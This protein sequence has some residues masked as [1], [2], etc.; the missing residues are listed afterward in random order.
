MNGYRIGLASAPCAEEFPRRAVP[1]RVLLRLIWG[2]AI[3]A[4]MVVGYKLLSL[5]SAPDDVL[6]APEP[7]CDLQQSR[8]TAAL[9]GGTAEL[10][11]LTRPIPLARPFQVVLDTRGVDA[12]KVELDVS[13]MEMDMG[14]NRI[15]LN[16]VGQGR[17]TAEVIIPVCIMGKMTWRAT[18]IIHTRGQ[19]LSIP[20]EFITGG[21]Y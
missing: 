15:P 13:G 20:Y 19:R 11:F 3:V 6:V 5:V 4:V 2:L 17:Y 10:E 9:P 1:R 8:C 18:A 12:L 16:P 21:T 7:G 14:Y